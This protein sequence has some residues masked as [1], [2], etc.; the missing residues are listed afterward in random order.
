MPDI[1]CSRC[2][3]LLVPTYDHK[4]PLRC[5]N[6]GEY[7][8]EQKITQLH[9]RLSQTDKPQRKRRRALTAKQQIG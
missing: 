8:D 2:Q 7:L 5:I 1:R 9:A 3:G 4:E 6:C